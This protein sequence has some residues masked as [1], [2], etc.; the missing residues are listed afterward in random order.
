[1]AK[2]YVGKCQVPDVFL[3][4]EAELIFQSRSQGRPRLRENMTHIEVKKHFEEQ[5]KRVPLGSLASQFLVSSIFMIPEE[6][7]SLGNALGKPQREREI[8]ILTY[9]DG[10][11][12][13]MTEALLSKTLEKRKNDPSW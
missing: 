13:L 3:I 8:A 5:K 10:T 1:M 6:S 12:Q 4:G 9:N 2:G 11:E 7:G